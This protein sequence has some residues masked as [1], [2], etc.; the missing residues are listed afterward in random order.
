M[1][2]FSFFTKISM[3]FL[4]K[5]NEG[6][7]S[8]SMQRIEEWRNAM[9]KKTQSNIHDGMEVN[10][11]TVSSLLKWLETEISGFTKV[12]IGQ[13]NLNMGMD[14]VSD[15]DDVDLNENKKVLMLSRFGMI[16][17]AA[18]QHVMRVPPC[19]MAITNH[20]LPTPTPLRRVSRSRLS[21]QRSGPRI[22]RAHVPAGR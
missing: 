19:D 18:V 5:N 8:H 1:I 20:E 3:L 16:I 22:V 17:N 12:S 11:D 9:T 10:H 4:G 15:M 21:D 6:L 2:F 14:T 13:L 7:T